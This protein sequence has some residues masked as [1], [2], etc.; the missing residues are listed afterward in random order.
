[1]AAR[2]LL[3]DDELDGCPLGPRPR[4]QLPGDID[5]VV[6]GQH[7]HVQVARNERRVKRIGRPRDSPVIARMDVEVRPT[8]PRSGG[9]R[10][11]GPLR[12]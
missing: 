2:D 6:I 1:M 9:H 8:G 10:P 11:V 7:G 4:D 5:A 3:A 12:P